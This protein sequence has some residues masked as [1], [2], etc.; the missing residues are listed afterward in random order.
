M[1][2]SPLA[3]FA[4]CAVLSSLGISIA[5][6]GLPTL[7]VA[8]G[9]SFQDVQWVVLA[10]LLAV[11]SLI[12]SV[13]R[14][15]DV[16]G[17]RRLL[18][19]G[20]V[21]FTMASA[22]CAMAPTL[23]VLIVA[24][25]I[26]GSGAAVMMVLTLACVAETM[27]SARVGRAMGLLGTMSAVGTAL[28]P[29]LG[30]A[31]IALFSWRAMFFVIVPLGVLTFVLIHR[32]VP[33]TRRDSALGHPG[34]D[35]PGTLLLA[36]SLA[37]YALAMTVGRGA[38]G[39]M[40][41]ALLLVTVLGVGFFLFVQTRVASP[42]IPLAMFRDPQLG[43]GLTLSAVVST[44]VM[45]TL[46]VGPFYLA[47]GLG[48]DS[49]R[50]GLVMTVGPL[51]TALSGLPAGRVV[52]RYGSS[53]M[54]SAGLLIMM[55]G[56]VA[57]AAAPV[58]T[59][60]IGYVGPLAVVTTGYALFQAANN[61]AVMVGANGDRRGLVS[62]VL[63]LSRNLGL[64]TGASVMGAV[65]ALG[66]ATADVAQASPDAASDGLRATFLVAALLLAVALAVATRRQFVVHSGRNSRRV[67]TSGAGGRGLSSRQ[68]P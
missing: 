56:V 10:Y 49:A 20:L 34:F 2:K 51:V 30:G 62:G 67:D 55:L 24:R 5:N 58:A 53:R 7:T 31:L 35:Y 54:T 18:L 41:L 59:G 26:Q 28:G 27:P 48:L 16:I 9:A 44:V 39:T 13:G 50:V 45:A 21:I 32:S 64:I 14:L 4:L 12:V 61:T 36:L 66:A 40:N 22:M 43:A 65:F 1:S 19:V 15:G 42:L 8:F 17:R 38:F 37:A 46:V 63:T 6:V 60:V 57:L 33:V 23:L 29:S 3:G 52:D 25:A 68:T 11:T 47:R